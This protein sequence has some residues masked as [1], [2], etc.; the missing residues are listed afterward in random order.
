MR[1]TNMVPE[2]MGGMPRYRTTTPDAV[3]ATL[4]VWSGCVCTPPRPCRAAG[5]GV[6][7]VG[8]LT[9]RRGCMMQV[10]QCAAPADC[11]EGRD[12]GRLLRHLAQGHLPAAEAMAAGGQGQG[13]G[14]VGGAAGGDGG[15]PEGG[16][17]GGAGGHKGQRMNGMKAHVHARGQCR[18][19]RGGKGS[20]GRATPVTTLPHLLQNRYALS[21]SINIRN[22][23]QGCLSHLH[24]LTCPLLIQCI[25]VHVL[26]SQS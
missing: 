6:L 24:A 12:G 4:A 25:C 3:C 14:G 22:R 18:M 2:V 1:Y 11:V 26:I 17:V 13:D 15:V 21:K 10:L 20:S 5:L 16:R 9:G 23:S 8:W 7:A 19:T